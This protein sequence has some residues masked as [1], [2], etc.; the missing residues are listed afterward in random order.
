MSHFIKTR[1]LSWISGCQRLRLVIL[2]LCLLGVI[3]GF[4]KGHLEGSGYF[5]LMIISASGGIVG[6]LGGLMMYWSWYF[7]QEFR[8]EIEM[9]F[10]ARR[11]AKALEQ[12][13][14]LARSVD[15]NWSETIQRT[16]EELRSLA[17][18]TLADRQ[19]WLEFGHAPRHG[20]TG[21]AAIVRALKKSTEPNWEPSS[22][23]W[24]MDKETQF[25]T[26]YWSL[27]AD[28]RFEVKK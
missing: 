28:R 26:I 25:Q 12:T 8:V 11:L 22:A 27:V 17:E 4:I 18:F 9:Y 24:A 20:F 6:E 2:C 5:E 7:P 3:A 16:K 19:S 21:V 1:Y 23:Y 10:F 13:R 15:E 14:A